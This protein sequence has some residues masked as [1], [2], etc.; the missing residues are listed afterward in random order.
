MGTSARR[1][2]RGWRLIAQEYARRMAGTTRGPLT[3]AVGRLAL[4]RRRLEACG[5]VSSTSAPTRCTCSSWTPTAARTRGRRT[6]RSRCC[7]WPNASAR[8]A[9]LDA[10]AADDLVKAVAAARQAAEQHD[11]DDMLAF[12]TSAVRD[13]TNSARVLARVRDETG[14]DLRGAL[15]PGRGADDLPRRAPLVRLVGRTAAGARHRRR[16]AGDRGRHRRGAVDRAVAAAGR[17]P[18]HPGA[19]VRRPAARGRRWTT[20][21]ST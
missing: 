7:A 20:C 11:V 6:R 1:S 19:P 14:V 17:R 10:A 8:T 13:A 16:L 2:A 4:S 9:S 21:A 12:A 18:A 15:R 3:A 5:S